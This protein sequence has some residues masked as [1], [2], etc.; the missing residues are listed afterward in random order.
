MRRARIRVLR[1]RYEQTA[2]ST[3]FIP[4]SIRIVQLKF[5]FARWYEYTRQNTSNPAG[6]IALTFV[7]CLSLASRGRNQRVVFRLSRSEREPPVAVLVRT[8]L[9]HHDYAPGTVLD[10]HLVARVAAAGPNRQRECRQQQ[11]ST[12]DIAMEEGRFTRRYLNRG[13]M[14]TGTC[15]DGQWLFR[16]LK[17]VRQ[18]PVV[19]ILAGL[20]SARCRRDRRG[21]VRLRSKLRSACEA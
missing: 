6:L 15:D 9:V 3:R 20:R 7:S 14:V 12:S 13:R 4:C 16:S 11:Q 5:S 17:T 8:E 10:A 1:D 21:L 18:G 19:S 2:M